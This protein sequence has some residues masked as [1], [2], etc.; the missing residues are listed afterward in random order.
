M[1]TDVDEADKVGEGVA[2][3]TTSPAVGATLPPEATA[4]ADPRPDP[5]KPI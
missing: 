5:L 1:R 2:Y 4:T 3:E